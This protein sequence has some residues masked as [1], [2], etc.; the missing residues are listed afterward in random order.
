MLQ[1]FC[2]GQNPL[3]ST[4][5]RSD[6]ADLSAYERDSLVSF[7]KKLKMTFLIRSSHFLQL[8]QPKLMTLSLSSSETLSLALLSF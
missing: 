3:N 8:T 6:K 1:D 4:Q 5:F 7:F 2:T